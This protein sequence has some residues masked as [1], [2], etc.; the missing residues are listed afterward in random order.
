MF[1]LLEEDIRGKYRDEL[2]FIYHQ[3][4][5]RVLDRLQFPQQEVPSMIDLQLEMT[6][7]CF[8]EVFTWLTLS[9]F[10][11]ADYKDYEVCDLFQRYNER[12]QKARLEIFRSPDMQ[13]LCKKYLT[14]FVHKGFL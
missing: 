2:I 9:I 13:E 12:G 4:F 10:H 14:Q 5:K 8:I 1:N 7:K 3:E 11:F 6:Q